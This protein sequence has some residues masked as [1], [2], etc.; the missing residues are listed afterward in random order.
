[1]S[2]P[3]VQSFETFG[4]QPQLSALHLQLLPNLLQVQLLAED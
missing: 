2:N 3:Q 1:M 4:G